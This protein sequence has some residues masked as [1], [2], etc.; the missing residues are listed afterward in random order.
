MIM[1]QKVYGPQRVAQQTGVDIFPYAIGKNK[2]FGLK[3]I[4]SKWG[5]LPFIV[6][7]LGDSGSIYDEFETQSVDERFAMR[8]IDEPQVEFQDVA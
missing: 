4:D 8:I 7:M 3:N 5:T 2:G 6:F 1:G